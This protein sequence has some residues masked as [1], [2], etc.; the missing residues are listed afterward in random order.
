MGLLLAFAVV[1]SS[2]ATFGF[3]A[4]AMAGVRLGPT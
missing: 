2:L 3:A 1:W 4:L